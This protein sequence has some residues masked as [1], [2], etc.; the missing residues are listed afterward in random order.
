MGNVTEFYKARNEA[1]EISVFA[2]TK[3]SRKTSARYKKKDTYS[4]RKN[5]KYNTKDVV[6]DIV[7]VVRL[8]CLEEDVWNTG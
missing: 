2:I 8:V 3:G 1:K 4:I 5:V 7:N 6:Y